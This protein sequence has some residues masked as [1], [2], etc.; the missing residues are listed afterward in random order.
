MATSAKTTTVKKGTTATTKKA[1]VKKVTTAKVVEEI[2]TPIIEE[3]VE[4]PTEVIETVEVS[5][6]IVENAIIEEVVESTEVNE[7]IEVSNEVTET[8]NDN[9][10]TE[11][12]TLEKKFLIEAGLD[13][14]VVTETMQTTVSGVIVPKAVAL[15]RDDTQQFL[16]V[17]GEGYEV[18]QNEQLIDLLLKVS[19]QTGLQ[20]HKGGFFGNGEKVFLQLK[21]DDFK[22]GND[23]IEG[24]ITGVNSFD[25]TT[26]LAFGPSNITI[27]C[28]NSFFAAFRELKT[29]VRHTKN[30]VI[31][32]EDILKQLDK[33]LVEEKRIFETI[34]RMSE[35]ESTVLHKDMVIRQ[36]FDIKPNVL[37]TDEEQVSTYK[38]NRIELLNGSIAHQTNEKGNTLW[39]LFSGVTHYTTHVM[40]R[41]DNNG[42]K[43]N[44]EEKLF[45][46]YGNRERNI[47]H[48]MAELIH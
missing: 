6:E 28:Q 20:L 1:P 18:Y 37:L 47:F 32:I 45:G 41:D 15:F 21:S 29:K 7:V 36:L 40:G 38:R 17:R 4:T 13:W 48:Q 42:E 16:S 2:V 14:K 11:P 43:D 33:S 35:V 24:Y 5:N 26:S 25:G 31:R 22:L 3:V 10:P 30:M 23:R 44:S 12:L 46:H 19:E 34:Q 39:G 8:S 27:S 9:E